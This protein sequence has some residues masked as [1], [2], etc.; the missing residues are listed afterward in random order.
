METKKEDVPNEKELDEEGREIITIDST[1]N[2]GYVYP[3]TTYFDDQE[4]FSENILNY[5]LCKIKF[6]IFKQ[7][8]LETVGGIQMFYKERKTGEVVS[9]GVFK[10]DKETNQLDKEL[11]LEPTEYITDYHVGIGNQVS[12]LSIVVMNMVQSLVTSLVMIFVLQI[13]RLVSLVNF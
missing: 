4:F 7:D 1:P 5:K 6:W 11:V 8:C 2:Y 12:L 9:P 3:D 13:H 10:G